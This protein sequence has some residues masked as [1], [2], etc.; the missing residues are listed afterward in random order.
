MASKKKSSTTPAASPAKSA[1]GPANPDIDRIRRLIRAKGETLL[2]LPK[3]TSVGIG[4][5]IQG[6]TKTKTP[7]L[8]FSVE[9]KVSL[10]GL[11]A[12]GVSALPTTIEFEGVS[13]PTDIVERSFRPSYAIVQ[14]KQKTNRKIRLDP[15][16]PGVSISHSSLTAGTLGAIVRD[17]TS[18]ETVLLSNWHVLHGANGHVG[19]TTVQPGPYDDNR[20]ASNAVGRL[21]RSHLGLAGDC[22]IASVES[23]RVDAT[24]LELGVAVEHVGKPDLGDVVVKS[25]R[26]TGIT[27]GQ[28]SRVDALFKMPYDD[29]PEQTIGGFEIE[30]WAERLPKDGEI[31]KG[32]DSGSA[33]MAVDAKGKSTTTMLGLHFGGDAEGSDGEFALACYAH[34]VFEKLEIEPL[35][36]SASPGTSDA[37]ATTNGST[38]VEAAERLRKGFNSSFLDF[39]VPRPKFQKSAADDLVGLAGADFIDYCHFTVWQSKSRKLPRCVAWNIDGARKRSLSRKGIPFIKDSREDLENYQW[40][41]EIYAGNP[42]D[43]GHVARRDDLVWGSPE[44]ARQGNIDS[45]FFTNMTPQH[46]A[47]NQSQ[48]KGQWGLLENA[49]LDEVVLKDLR[50][51]VMGGPI[52][53]K[54]D[55]PYRGAQLPAEFWKIVFYVDDEDGQS[56]ARAFVL[57]Q[58][59]LLKKLKPESLELGQFRWY[60]V[61]LATVEKKTGMRLDQKLHK[62]DTKFPQAVGVEVARLVE[63]GRFFD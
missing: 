62:L 20:I 44:E 30:P 8:Q 54:E 24:Q 40:G 16:M 39:P 57:T 36:N 5:K 41:D 42:L 37:N 51:S 58:Q 33:W 59:D 32:G 9:R 28:V 43:R 26:T 55:R 18:G 61:P 27:Y 31:S 50:V 19:D 6:D 25:G 13:I 3:V 14:L 35:T 23:R 22:A 34:S 10:E 1:P 56:K 53:A 47:F 2:A 21:L 63:E 4:Y 38:S 29:M 11:A 12:E 45:F 48:L 49:I 52:L 7:S 17:T 60:Q 15:V 46:E